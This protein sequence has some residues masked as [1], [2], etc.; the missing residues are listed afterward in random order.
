MSRVPSGARQPLQPY[1]NGDPL[2]PG[3]EEEEELHLVETALDELQGW[4]SENP[5]ADGEDEEELALE[6]HET[7][8]IL[9]T[10]LAQKK[11]TFSQSV[12][13][14]KAK[15]LARGY[16][17]WRSK[18]SGSSTTGSSKGKGKKGMTVEELKSITRCAKCKKMG[19]WHRECPEFAKGKGKEI[20][21]LEP[22]G[23]SFEEASFCGLLEKIDEHL[24]D[25]HEAR[26]EKETIHELNLLETMK[27][28]FDR[29]LETDLL[30]NPGDGE[31][32][33]VSTTRSKCSP[34][35]PIEPSKHEPG[36]DQPD[37][38]TF[39]KDHD[40]DSLSDF[41]SY[42][43]RMPC[44]ET[45]NEEIRGTEH[46]IFWKERI[47]HDRN[48]ET[49]RRTTRT[50]RDPCPEIDERCCATLDTGC[51]RMAVGRETLDVLSEAMPQD[52]TIGVL[53]QEHRFRSVHGR[54]STSHVA[55]VPTSLG[56][57]G[58]VLRPAIFDEPGSR[59]AP[60]LISL[61]FMMFCRSVLHLDP[62]DGLRIYFR[63]FKFSVRCHL[64]PTGALRIPL[65][66]FNNQQL[67]AVQEAQRLFRENHEEFEVYRVESRETSWPKQDEDKHLATHGADRADGDRQQESKTR[68]EE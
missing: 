48:Q 2:H 8:E 12:Q 17:D 66:H 32:A 60:F 45:V 54:S 13:L 19:H 35:P 42:N 4:N 55:A 67:Q 14:K 56:H 65:N 46:E 68:G 64:G 51:Q 3:Q 34:E 6:E 7:A 25:Y 33:A 21:F 23:D 50:W 27:A 30:E 43:D 22:S 49:D 5:G 15:E 62:E 26:P 57:R 63:R 1:M 40:G 24:E 20:H 41:G 28:D 38:A 52:V 39:S 36:R 37:Q 9:S 10:M 61:L 31:Q 16:G 53:P 44:F 47:S 18:G 29:S 58:S 11:K 59:S